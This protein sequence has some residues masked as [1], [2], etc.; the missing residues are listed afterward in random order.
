M[1][2]YELGTPVLNSYISLE[3]MIETNKARGTKTQAQLINEIP[4]D[5]VGEMKAF[6]T[7]PL[8]YQTV[9]DEFSLWEHSS[10][11]LRKSGHFPDLP[12]TI[13]AR[14]P[15]VSAL[16][17][18]EHGTP[19]EEAFLYEQRWHELQQELSQLSQKGEMVIAKGSDHE[20]HLDRPDQ[21]IE[22]LLKSKRND[23]WT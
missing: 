18:I 15:K 13:I 2:L 9:A 16:P 14:A 12:L 4:S 23:S 5:S 21:V 10:E 7:S 22:C 19:E 11:I 6:L 8:P 1:T 20:I 17:F 3:G